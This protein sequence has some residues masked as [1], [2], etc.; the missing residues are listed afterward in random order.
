MTANIVTAHDA[1]TEPGIIVIDDEMEHLT[2][3][4]DGLDRHGMS[5]LRVHCEGDVAGIGPWPDVRLI[6]ADLHLGSGVLTADPKT[7]FSVIGGLLEETI[8]PSGPYMMVLWTMYP[9]QA[10]ALRTFLLERLRDVS[11]PFDVLPLAKA[12]YLDGEGNVRNESALV[13]AF[14]DL[15]AG[16]ARPE[17]AL[18]LLGAWGELDD[19]EVDALIGEIYASRRG[20]TGRPVELED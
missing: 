9:E 19:D 20:D 18:A 8:R 16:W 14:S 4:A 17:G 15:A 12:D 11:K 6:V 5:C 13:R 10:P 3:L 7:D 2:G 1:K